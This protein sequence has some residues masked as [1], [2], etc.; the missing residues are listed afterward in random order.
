MPVC[1]R[2][3]RWPA[4]PG[5]CLGACFV[6]RVGL[7][8]FGLLFAAAVCAGDGIGPTVK[9]VVEFTRIVQPRNSDP[10]ALQTRFRPTAARL[11]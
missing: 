9:E 1:L 3:R 5:Q 8:A 6:L 7:M 4:H 10:D 2:A 11:S